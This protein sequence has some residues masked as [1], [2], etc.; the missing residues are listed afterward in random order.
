MVLMEKIAGSR[1]GIVLLFL[2]H[3]VA[4]KQRKLLCGGSSY[5]LVWAGCSRISPLKG[6]TMRTSFRLNT[7]CTAEKE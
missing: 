4:T 3:V 6:K 5:F 7:V 2:R 1:D